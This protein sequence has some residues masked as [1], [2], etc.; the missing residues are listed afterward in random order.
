MF[1]LEPSKGET[2]SVRCSLLEQHKPQILL[3][4]ANKVMLV[5]INI[6]PQLNLELSRKIQH[7]SIPGLCRLA[8][9]TESEH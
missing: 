5:S 7:L 8:V 3:I 4:T 9:L 6:I 2:L 1:L